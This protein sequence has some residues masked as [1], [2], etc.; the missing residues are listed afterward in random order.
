[1]KLKLLLWSSIIIG[2]I[3]MLLFPNSETSNNLKSDDLENISN[4]NIVFEKE[5]ENIVI[6]SNEKLISNAITEQKEEN[7]NKNE[8]K[9][10]KEKEVK[11]KTKE[12][13]SYE[14]EIQVVQEV[15]IPKVD[16][17][18][19]IIEEKPIK[20]EK[21]ETIEQKQETRQE[22]QPKEETKK[23]NQD[24][25]IPT[26]KEEYKYNDEMTQRIINIIN[27][28]P[29]TYMISDGYEIKIDSSITG[30]TNQFT[31]S[32]TRVINMITYKAGT[33]KVYAQDYYLNGEYLFTECYLF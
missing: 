4:Q 9:V 12:T 31:F 10:E 6:L 18:P 26:T 16:E 15:S 21:E 1:M 2:S 13:V 19:N 30:L 28:N 22:T 20:E 24:L 32:E 3:Y 33:I 23:E 5:E 27:S 7:I 17:K 11:K 14:P 8:T 25:I 29:S